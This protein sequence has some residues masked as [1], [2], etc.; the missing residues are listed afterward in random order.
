MKRLFWD[1][2]TSPNRLWSWRVGRKI[3]LGPDVIDKERNIICICYKWQ[4][5]RKVH[6]LKWDFWDDKKMVEDFVPVLE[7][8]DELVAHNGDRFDMRWYNGRHL[9]HHLPPIPTSK[10]VDTLKIARKHFYLNSYRLD[11]LAKKLL[12]HG[13]IETGFGLW[14]AICTNNDPVSMA[15][16]IRYCKRD[17]VLVQELWELEQSYEAPKT[18]SAVLT[19]GD[20]KLRWMCPH[21]ASGNV[22]KSKNITTAKGMI[23]HQMK[24]RACGRYY[25][26]ADAVHNWYLTAKK[27]E[28]LEVE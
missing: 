15:K 5:Q 26:I 1:I 27:V 10:T 28:K 2:E 13:K 21:C 25:T 24:C 18:H 16:M 14:K 17:V 7:E 3:S 9:I 19:T 8:A 12:G 20:V 4:H 22:K 23:Q 6:H 11:Y